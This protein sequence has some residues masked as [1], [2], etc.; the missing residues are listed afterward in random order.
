MPM[1]YLGCDSVIPAPVLTV[2]PACLE[3]FFKERSWTSQDDKELKG[4][5]IRLRRRSDTRR[6]GF[7]KTYYAEVYNKMIIGFYSQLTMSLLS[8]SPPGD[9]SAP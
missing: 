3:S 5:P 7:R 6:D 1:S 8:S 9:P 4:F 2:I